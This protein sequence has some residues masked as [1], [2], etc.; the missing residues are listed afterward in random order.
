MVL[1]PRGDSVDDGGIGDLVV[2]AVVGVEAAVVAG[3]GD[4]HC[5]RGT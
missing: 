1:T 3:L 4:G 2:V 5:C